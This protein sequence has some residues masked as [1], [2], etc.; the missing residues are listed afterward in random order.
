MP[1]H[2]P[3]STRGLTSG[4]GNLVRQLLGGK[5]RHWKPQH[6]S[7]NYSW[8]ILRSSRKKGRL[9]QFLLCAFWLLRRTK[10]SSLFVQN[11]WSWHWAI[12]KSVSGV[13]VIA[14]HLFFV[15]I[16]FVSLLALQLKNAIRCDKAIAKMRSA[17]V[18]SRLKK[19]WLLALLLVTPTLIPKSIGFS[20]R[21]FMASAEVPVIGMIMIR[22]TQYS[23]LSVSNLLSNTP[24]CT[25][26]LFGILLTLHRQNLL[27]LVPLASMSMTSCTSLKTLLSKLY[28]VVSWL[29]SARWISWAWWNGFWE[30]TL[31]GASRPTPSW[32]I[33][34]KRVSL[35]I[36]SRASF[37]HPTMWPL[38]PHLTVPVCP[39]TQLLLPLMTM[40]LLLNF[41]I[42]LPTK[43]VTVV[44]VG[45]PLPPVLISLWFTPSL[46]LTSINHQSGTW[47]LPFRLSTIF[48]L[49]MI[50]ASTSRQTLS[51]Q[52]IP[53]YTFLLW[54]T[55]RLIPMCYHLL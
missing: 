31:H 4:Q 13:K 17:M 26:V 44:P 49:P 34:I 35:Q 12:L 21:R 45:S 37:E 53:A 32:F 19:Q 9:K 40:I 29:S 16:P 43:A 27:H 39:L 48:I 6:L 51:L 14:L 3:P 23:S 25:L 2:T 46:H 20:W 52:C 7:K 22:S 5:T 55:S 18:F 30:F 8:R 10:I 42:R 28:S 1:S 36:L 38:L 41:D 33:S 11:L 24:A 15:K 47:R 50:T 54:P